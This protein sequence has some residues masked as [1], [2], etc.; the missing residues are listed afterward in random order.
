MRQIACSRIKDI[1]YE[2]SNPMWA[3]RLM[4]D[5]LKDAI[6]VTNDTIRKD[7]FCRFSQAKIGLKEVEQVADQMVKQFKSSDGSRK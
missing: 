5:Y 4:R 6:K 2:F 3:S 7:M 1:S